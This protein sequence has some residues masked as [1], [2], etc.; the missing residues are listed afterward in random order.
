MPRPKTPLLSSQRI[1]DS[2]LAVI[3]EVGT[4]KFSIH[5][6]ARELGV[7]PPSIYYYFADRDVLIASVCLRVLQ[8]VHVPKKRASE[9]GQRLVRDAIAYYRAL[10]RHPNL[11]S[12]LLL[13]RK[14]RAGAAERFEDALL[15]M[16]DAGIAPADGLAIIDGIEGIALSWIAFQHAPAVAIDPH[17]YPALTAASGR[18]KFDEA[19]Y[20][21]TISALIAGARLMYAGPNAKGR[22]ASSGVA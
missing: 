11:A 17:R 8:D 16:K 1:L 10:C 7:K 13:E 12:A 21:R 5:R 22:S 6:V 18:Q 20:K 19:S 9:W 15:Q 14:T 4:D 2:A 3:D